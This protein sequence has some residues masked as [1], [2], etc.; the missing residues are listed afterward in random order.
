[1]SKQNSNEITSDIFQKSQVVSYISESNIAT[2][3]RENARKTTMKD[4]LIY[5][6]LQK[7]HLYRVTTATSNWLT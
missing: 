4:L 5:L 2:N 6:W 7:I 3:K 1:M